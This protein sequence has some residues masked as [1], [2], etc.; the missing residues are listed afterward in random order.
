[1]SPA[2]IVI[3]IL[4]VLCVAGSIVLA[5][6]RRKNGRSGCSGG[7][8]GCPHAGQCERRTPPSDTGHGT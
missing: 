2:D 5:L 3:L 7:C 6:R 1:M 8:T 4:A